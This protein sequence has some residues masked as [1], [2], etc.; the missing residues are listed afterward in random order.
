M[1]TGLAAVGLREIYT[2]TVVFRIRAP[3]WIMASQEGA[4]LAEYI[5]QAF[6][7]GLRDFFQSQWLPIRPLLIEW[8]IRCSVVAEMFR[9]SACHEIL[10]SVEL[11]SLVRSRPR[12]NCLC[13]QNIGGSN[14]ERDWRQWMYLYIYRA[15]NK[16]G[17]LGAQLDM[18]SRI[19]CRPNIH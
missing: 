3:T 6:I 13:E 15:D 19:D 12:S 11:D 4:I 14:W 10:P 8:P 2:P 7:C 18:H 9:G 16:S 5:L 17:L 1:S